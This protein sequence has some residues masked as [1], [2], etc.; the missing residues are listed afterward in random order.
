MSF[1]KDNMFRNAE[2]YPE[3]F[4]YFS[5]SL[6]ETLKQLKQTLKVA[7]EENKR[8][9]KH[10]KKCITKYNNVKWKLEES[11]CRNVEVIGMTT[12]GA[13]K[14]RQL[15][16]LLQPKI[17]ELTF[18]FVIVL[19]SFFKFVFFNLCSCCGGSGPSA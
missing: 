9:V 19:W 4:F 1:V 2:N 5:M 10:Y 6:V 11:L 13:A 8:Q 18:N 14:R 3:W 17:G 7:A 12:T 16:S 15:L